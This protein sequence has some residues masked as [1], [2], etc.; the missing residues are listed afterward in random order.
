MKRI[1]A[2]LRRLFVALPLL[3][4]GS[5]Y[6]QDPVPEGMAR[7]IVEVDSMTGSNMGV[8]MLLDSEAG[9]FGGAYS[10][11]SLPSNITSPGN[12]RNREAF[13]DTTFDYRIPAEASVSDSVPTGLL[14]GSTAVLDIPAGTYDYILVYYYMGGYMSYV[15]GDKEKNA[16]DAVFE[17][18]KT[19]KFHVNGSS[20]LTYWPPVGIELLEAV[21]PEWSHSLGSGDEVSVR[22]V[23]TGMETL[24]TFRAGYSVNGA[25]TVWEEVS[26][27]LASGDTLTYT[28]EQ[29]PDFSTMGTLSIDFI[30]E[31][32]G[33][34]D[35]SDNRLSASLYHPA[36]R[37]IPF[38]EDFESSDSM[39]HWQVE[40]LG[41]NSYAGN[42]RH[43]LING[44]GALESNGFVNSSCY[45]TPAALYMVSDPFRIK[46]GVNHVSFYYTGGSVSNPEQI[47]LFYGCTP[48][49]GSMTKAGGV[50]SIFTPVMFGP[51][52]LQ[53]YGWEMA[54]FNIDFAQDSVYYFA[55]GLTTEGSGTHSVYIDEFGIDTGRYNIL[56]DFELVE[57]VLPHST[58]EM[59]VDSIG[60]VVRNAGRAPMAGFSMACRI[61]GFDTLSF[62]SQDSLP[63][64]EMRTVWFSEKVDFSEEGAYELLVT[65]TCPKQDIYD[66]DTLTTIVYHYAPVAEFPY[67]A[68]FT[69]AGGDARNEWYA[70]TADNWSYDSEG[71]WAAS[72][73]A[74]MIH[75]RC[76]DLEEGVYRIVLGYKAG[77]GESYYQLYDNFRIGIRAVGDTANICLLD[78]K[79]QNTNYLEVSFDTVFEVTEAGAYTFWLDPYDAT[80]FALASFGVEEAF[81]NDIRLEQFFSSTLVPVMPV[82]QIN[83]THVFSASIRN[84]GLDAPENPRVALSAG[85][86]EAV[87]MPVSDSIPFALPTAEAGT[88]LEV[89]AEALMAATDEYPED[90]SLSIRVA[91]S[92]SVMATDQAVLG[93]RISGYFVSA[94]TGNLYTV[95]LPDTLTSFTFSFA[96][97]DGTDSLTFRL[98]ALQG[99]TNGQMWLGDTLAEYR[100]RMPR[101]AG[102]TTV[103]LPSLSLMPGTYFAA[104]IDPRQT[105]G[106]MSDSLADG[107]FYS[108][109]YTGSIGKYENQ[110]NM[111]LRLNFGPER[112]PYVEADLAI[113]SIS[114]PADS[115][116]MTAEEEIT[117]MVVNY[118]NVD[119]SEVP[120]LWVIDGEERTET[121]DIAAATAVSL[122]QE[123]D[124]SA[125]GEHEVSVKVLW[126]NDPDTTN[127]AMQ[128]TFVCVERSSNES[129]ESIDAR[130]WPN[131]ASSLVHV[132]VSVPVERLE[133]LDSKGA[134]CHVW[135]GRSECVELN[136]EGW[137]AG[138]YLLR[139]ETEKGLVI[140]KVVVND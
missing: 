101:E 99:D 123:A 16:D 51:P 7:I 126:P 22:V 121:V 107:C 96:G 72:A 129:A 132:Q 4:W 70:D 56:P 131:P 124:F 106:Y 97:T 52:Q 37:A 90:N 49:I 111:I 85:D 75:S 30:V 13:Y 122:V 105:C 2:T 10:T 136:V 91:V 24:E 71:R 140:K 138:V 102:L 28:F 54:V 48:D 53:T 35:L 81:Y 21:L 95:V 104:L 135:E 127:N 33:D 11:Y 78:M 108:A 1:L 82:R 27:N 114:G 9:S 87:E 120:V 55:I 79:Q 80:Y 61:E 47:D 14:N 63:V 116:L 130:I 103:G 45:T 68:D 113:H 118:A 58:C 86:A 18:G 36:V 137:S 66:N 19:Y 76:M 109:S 5:A 67:R 69:D 31:A 92:D 98:Y 139:V 128:K 119:V 50:S 60:A 39:N 15:N 133:I 94:P 112:S 26:C 93:R 62:E 42:W 12:W 46:A 6:A 59:G 77:Y 23:N 44:K 100:F 110:G 17:T 89:K 115:T 8:H 41:G 73:N 29:N 65:G 3:G 74:G 32:E 38:H 134:V 20:M 117:A 125:L 83:T 40:D 64:G 84:R 57:L 88:M 25:D 34:A 43:S